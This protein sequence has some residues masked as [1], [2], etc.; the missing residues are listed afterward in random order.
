VTAG[1]AQSLEP[2]D[3]GYRDG[4]HDIHVTHRQRR[5]R[6]RLRSTEYALGYSHGRI[7]GAE[8]PEYPEW[9]PDFAQ[10]PRVAH[11]PG[12]PA[13]FEASDGPG[14]VQA[15]GVVSGATPRP[16]TAPREAVA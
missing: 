5:K 8:W 10:A 3:Q 12:S 6:R 11:A 9:W 1:G 4:W 13:R 16:P 2:Y 14:A 15:I 7:D